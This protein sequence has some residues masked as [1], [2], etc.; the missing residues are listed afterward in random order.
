MNGKIKIGI[1]G[2]GNVGRGVR[3]AT[4]QNGDMELVAIF[5]RR[6]VASLNIDDPNIEVLNVSEADRFKDHIDVMILCGG[7]ATDLTQQGPY[8]AEKFNTVDSFDTHARIPEYFNAIDRA[9]RQGKKTSLISGGWDPGLFS[10]NRVM[11]ESILPK[12][13]GY[14][15]WGPG[16]SL[17]HSDAIRRIEG[18]KDAVQ[19]TI[20][21]ESA[22]EKVRKG[23]MPELK[24][25]QAF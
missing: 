1:V 10:I 23:E 20:P 25:R 2:Y 4:Y 5:T 15:F 13:K 7:S 21:I 6:D 8:F 11:A 24:N 12:G 22:I 3:L 17:G 18:V 9:S 19:Y 16:V 14:T